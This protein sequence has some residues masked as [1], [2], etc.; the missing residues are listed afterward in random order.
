M[1]LKIKIKKVLTELN[2]SVNMNELSQTK[3][4]KNIDN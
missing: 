1:I 3:A 2:K 4:T